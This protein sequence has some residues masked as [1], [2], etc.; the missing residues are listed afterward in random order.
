[1]MVKHL[2][3]TRVHD[4]KKK[5]RFRKHCPLFLVKVSFFEFPPSLW[6]FFFLVFYIEAND[7]MKFI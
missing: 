3:L 7:Y 4:P 6:F 2:V 5:K 1:M